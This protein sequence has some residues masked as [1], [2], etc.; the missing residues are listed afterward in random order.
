M[1]DNDFSLLSVIVD[2]GGGSKV[3]REAKKHGIF[4]GTIIPG[5]G[6]SKNR[7]L[8]FLEL[9]DIRREIVL[10]VT[11][12][13]LAQNALMYLNEKFRFE[14]NG[15][16]IAFIYPLSGVF[17]ASKCKCCEISKKEV[18]NTMYQAI[19]TI[20]DRGNA[21]MVIDAAIKAGARGGTI[22]NAR[23]SGIHETSKLFSL[24]IEPEKEIVLIISN[25][26]NTENIVSSIREMLQIDEPGKGIL[27]VSDLSQAIGL[28]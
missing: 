10:M 25:A 4:G 13:C 6:T 9:S 2:F 5:K 16:G 12:N 11:E 1:P 15:H 20:V 3:L 18:E 7:F 21:E 17:G 14:K 26:E 28:Y 19:T 8:S 22:I 23:G 24:E 27:F